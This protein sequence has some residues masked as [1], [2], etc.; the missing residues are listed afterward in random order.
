MSALALYA[1]ASRLRA[2]ATDGQHRPSVAAGA[3]VGRPRQPPSERAT[4]R[5][6]RR[7]SGQPGFTG[8]EIKRASGLSR[9]G[10][11]QKL[12]RLLARGELRDKSPPGGETGYRLSETRRVG[13][14]E[15]PSPRSSGRDIPTPMRPRRP[16][17]GVRLFRA[18]QQCAAA[19]IEVGFG[20]RARFLDTRRSAP[21][22]HDRTAQPGAD[23]R[24]RRASRR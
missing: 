20:E 9:A 23:C 21:H 5:G 16:Y 6:C 10:V 13:T 14:S 2:P 1:L 8:A 22:D 24:R 12:R 15:S 17:R 7:S 19:R 11:A 4:V 3:R 18:G